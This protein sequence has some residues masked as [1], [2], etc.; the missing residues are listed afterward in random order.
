MAWLA[1][2]V[3]AVVALLHAGR[4]QGRA[5]AEHQTK[6]DIATVET[7]RDATETI[8]RLG[9]DAVREHARQRMRCT[10]GELLRCCSTS[11]PVA[12]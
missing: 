9:D 8:E 4:R 5:Q 7:G 1:G 12:L 6:A 2:L 10:E 11:V 3:L